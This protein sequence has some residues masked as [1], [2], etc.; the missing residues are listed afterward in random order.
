[1]L[2]PVHTFLRK[3]NRF[4]HLLQHD[5]MRRMLELLLLQPPQV[6]YRPALL[7]REDAAMLEHEGAHLLPV[8]TKSL[9]RCGAGTNKITHG[10]VAFVRH[11]DRSKLPS[12]QKLGQSNCITSVGLH[13]IARLSW[14]Q[15]RRNN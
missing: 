12:A 4:D 14:N 9:D 15:R 1:M 10:L 5:L 7:A 11:P 13:L 8:H 2:Q 6:P 3:P